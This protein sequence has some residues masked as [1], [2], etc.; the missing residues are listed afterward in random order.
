MANKFNRRNFLKAFGATWLIAQ[1]PLWQSCKETNLFEGYLTSNQTKILQQTL[2]I[3]FPSYKNSPT[4]SILKTPQHILN[5]LK[6]PYIDPDEKKFLINGTNWLNEIAQEIKKQNFWTL[7]INE[8]T[9]LVYHIKKKNWGESW[10]SKILTLTFES[11]LL[12]PIYDVNIKEK[13]WKWLHHT[14][15]IPRPDAN[16]KYTSILKRKKENVIITRLDQL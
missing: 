6:D 11:L 12:D 14:P 10:L 16:N 8:Q 15:G 9:E 2:L 4:P 13:G 5:Y 1:L 3:L 7:S